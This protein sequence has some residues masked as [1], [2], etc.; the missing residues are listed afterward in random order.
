MDSKNFC[1]N[2][3]LCALILLVFASCPLRAGESHPLLLNQ[4]PRVLTSNL[5]SQIP[6]LMKKGRVPGLQIALIQDGRVI[7]HKSYG[8]KNATTG[9]PVT[10]DTIFEAASLTKPLFAYA[11]MRLAEQGVLDLDAPLVKYASKD[12]IEKELGHPLDQPDF[13]RD[14]Y[15][16]ITARHVLSHS[17]G[18]AHGESGTPYPLSFKPGTAY[19]YSADGYYLLQLAVERL[20]GQSLETIIGKYVLDP[21]G[22]KD[23]SMIW[24]EEYERTSASGHGFFGRS[25]AF[26]KRQ[27][28]HAAATLY[29]TAGEYARFIC[30]VLNGEGLKKATLQQ[31]LAPQIEVDKKKGLAW[32]MGFGLQKDV[33]GIAIWQWGDYSIFRNYV[34]A[35]PKQK[36]GIVYLANSAYGLSICPDIVSSSIGGQVLGVTHLGYDH[37]DSPTYE[38]LWAVKDKGPASAEKLFAEAKAHDRGKFSEET[39]SGLGGIL[40]EEQLYS[41]AVAVLAINVRE[42]PESA[43]AVSELA[44]ATLE[45]GDPEK[46]RELYGQALELGK[47]SKYDART[48]AW[49]LS[50]IKALEGPLRLPAEYLGTLAGNYETRRVTLENGSLHYFR[51]D[52]ANPVPR[53]LVA[54]S[55]DT[56]IV[57]GLI[58]LR[59][60]FEFD[61]QGKATRIVGLYEGGGRDYMNRDR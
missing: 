51:K 3:R 23:S 38:F 60:Q 30:A 8:I 9:E 40:S 44:R 53:Q 55:R 58:D 24:R 29:T 59:L 28:A 42:H 36:A 15:E 32:S 12:Q 50:Y 35:Y 46:A 48:A 16:K 10:D 11:V 1:R 45:K 39:I 17:S 13:H 25:E 43:K 6:Q 56:F 7:W 21:L 57:M 54:L 27:E 41:E 14:W 5:D 49:A 33:N 18:M 26:R 19:K 2:L 20:L 47:G 31:M 52:A 37:F 61:S 22:M 34:I 4:N